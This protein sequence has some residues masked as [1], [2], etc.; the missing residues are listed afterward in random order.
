MLYLTRMNGARAKR[1]RI[2]LTVKTS[3]VWAE[4]L[5]VWSTLSSFPSLKDNSDHKCS[6]F[7]IFCG[8]FNEMVV[9]T[10]QMPSE[11]Q[12]SEIYDISLNGRVQ[13]VILKRFLP[14]PEANNVS[15]QIEARLQQYASQHGLAAPVYAFNRFGMISARC[16]H[17]LELGEMEDGYVWERGLS[18]ST[19]RQISTVNK[20]LGTGVQEV[21][22][23]STAMYEKIGMYNEDPNIGNYM[24]F[25]GKPVQVDFGM[26][27]FKDEESFGQWAATVPNV[28]SN[29]LKSLLV[30]SDPPAYPPDYYWYDTFLS[31]GQ[32]ETRAWTK[33][34]W[35]SYHL[36]LPNRRQVLIQQLE[37]GRL[38]MLENK[39]TRSSKKPIKQIDDSACYKMHALKV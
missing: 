34:D 23:V 1:R 7:I 28:T 31:D 36:D 14:T 2:V 38:K 16:E 30:P 8:R 5:R 33:T 37:R 11:G 24:L 18:K 27:R 9:E 12:H 25:R 35:Q 4:I 39:S 26:N 15:P 10:S 20:A 22:A 13:P 29:A 3:S 19:M 6:R 17:P 32:H 21:L